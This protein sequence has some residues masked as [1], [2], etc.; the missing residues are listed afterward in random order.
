M[1]K[2]L[3]IALVLILSISMFSSCKKKNTEPLSGSVMLYTTIDEEVAMAIKSNFEKE[4]PGIVLDYY[5]GDLD[6]VNRKI[7]AEFDSGQIN[8]DVVFL[9]DVLTLEDMKSKSRLEAYKSS[10]AKKIPVAYK[11]NDNFYF[12]GAVTT[13]G[14]GI[15]K[16][17][18]FGIEEKTAPKTWNDFLN[19]DFSGKM[20][21]ANPNSDNYVKYWVMAMM[22]NPKYGDT[23][24]R[25]LKDNGLVIRSNERDVLD[26]IVGG[27]SSI[28]I[29]YDEI[30]LSFTKEFED[31]EFQYANSDNITMLTGVALV[32]DAI[33]EVNGKLLMDYLLSKKGQ[34]VLVANGLVS[35]RTDVKNVLNAK[36]VISKSLK[37]DIEDIKQKGNDYITI[38]NDIFGD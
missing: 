38:F 15:N 12:A 28:G 4:Y 37:V 23:Y 26:S 20:A 27:V 13:M 32:K 3:S 8:A 9:S 16:S 35:A 21:I 36:N 34:E 7:D 18:D 14:I 24:F 1:K 6:S 2:F 33:N 25:K 19:K 31:F 22:Q 10:E 17:K 30:A 11:D 5:Y 29:C